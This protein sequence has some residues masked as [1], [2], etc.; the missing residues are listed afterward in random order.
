MFTEGYSGKKETD[1]GKEYKIEKYRYNKTKTRR[2]AKEGLIKL[3][4]RKNKR[5]QREGII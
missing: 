2:L 5:G 1:R 4:T 3:V